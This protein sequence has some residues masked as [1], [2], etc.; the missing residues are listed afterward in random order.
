MGTN[1]YDDILIATP[2]DTD[3]V[4]AELRIDIS[5]RSEVHDRKEQRMPIHEDIKTTY[6]YYPFGRHMSGLSTGS[7]SNVY[8]SNNKKEKGNPRKGKG[9]IA[10]KD[11]NVINFKVKRN[12]TVE[13]KT[14]VDDFTKKVVESMASLKTSRKVLLK[15]KNDKD[16]KLQYLPYPKKLN[17][18]D[19]E[20]SGLGNIFGTVMPKEEYELK[21][22]K[23]ERVS[24][25]RG[26]KFKHQ[27][28]F[29][30]GDVIATKKTSTYAE[31]VIL[32]SEE[33]IKNNA[34]D[35]NLELIL[36]ATEESL[37]SQQNFVDRTPGREYPDRLEEKEVKPKLEVVKKEYQKKNS[38]KKNSKNVQE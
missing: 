34:E 15:V 9:G 17:E 13:F 1:I 27:Q 16:I 38:K 26:K 5:S 30:N 28:E 11:G 19:V 14:P 23:E 35:P 3:T 36:T 33:S 25:P 32:I 6:G 37:H 31:Q 4:K 22:S 18:E 24:L 10:D 2:F 21:M 7:E 12:G 8:K 20:L 29:E